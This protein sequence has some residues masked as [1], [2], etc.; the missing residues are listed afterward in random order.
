MRNIFNCNNKLEI[1][2][3]IFIIKDI[4]YISKITQK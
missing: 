4:G 2:N 3:N 1:Y